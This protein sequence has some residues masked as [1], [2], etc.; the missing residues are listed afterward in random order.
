MP[1]DMAIATSR[2]RCRLR[3]KFFQESAMTLPVRMLPARTGRRGRYLLLM[4]TAFSSWAMMPSAILT[5]RLHCEATFS[6]CVTTMT[7]FPFSAIFL[8]MSITSPADSLSSAPVGS[9]ARMIS[10]LL[11]SAR[12]MATRCFVRPKAGWASWR[13]RG[14]S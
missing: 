4:G 8:R 1:M 13:R 3:H 11:A 6:E 2:L 9:S 10:G 7:S 14:P 12:A 5:T